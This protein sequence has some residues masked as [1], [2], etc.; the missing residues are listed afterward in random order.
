[1]KKHKE[2]RADISDA[3]MIYYLFTGDEDGNPAKFRNFLGNKI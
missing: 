3:G 2:K 1:M